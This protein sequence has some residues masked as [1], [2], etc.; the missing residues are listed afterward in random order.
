MIQR[1]A[2][3]GLQKFWLAFF[4]LIVAVTF[5][6]SPIMDSDIFWHLAS[7]EWIFD[8]RHIPRTDI[9]SYT[10]YGNSWIHHE[11]G[12][13]FI[14]FLTMTFFGV[15]GLNVLAVVLFWGYLYFGGRGVSRLTR[16]KGAS[17][18]VVFLLGYLS[19]ERVQPRPH[20]FTNLF[21]AI[22]LYELYGWK[23]IE[24]KHKKKLL[25]ISPFLFMVWANLHGGVLI[26]LALL[27]VYAVGFG[28][29]S[30]ITEGSQKKSGLD[31]TLFYLVL[32]CW[33][34]VLM[35]PYFFHIYTFPFSH[36]RL[37][38]VIGHTLEWMPP[39]HPRFRFRFVFHGYFGL[40][41][42]TLLV[43]CFRWRRQRLEILFPGVLLMFLSIRHARYTALFALWALPLLACSIHG[44]R[45]HL[46]FSP[47]LQRYRLVTIGRTL[48][49]F[50]L[51]YFLIG[52][53]PVEWGVEKQKIGMGIYPH[54]LP[55][56]AV[57]F[58][59]DNGVYQ[60][61]YT[62]D[63]FGSFLI[64]S[65]IPAFIDGRAPVYDEEFWEKTQKSLSNPAVFA[66]LWKKWD[67]G[68]ALL[69]VYLERSMMP[70]HDYLS[71]NP[72]WALIYRDEVASI[73]VDRRKE[74]LA[75]ID[76]FGSKN[77]PL[78]H[79]KNHILP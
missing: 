27:T 36:M 52:G 39:Y 72:Q 59:R 43:I 15:Y 64:Y 25:L 45:W 53:V 54:R 50:I 19:M 10:A 16:S 29:Q 76:K 42:L 70:L 40:L 34:A 32:A 49:F 2:P 68:A 8:N 14:F 24:Q 67:F 9:F 3:P 31:K 47:L 77:K 65:G 35:N 18:L 46:S 30:L 1:I 41:G 57:G 75:L 38:D 20:L 62:K 48:L 12:A 73:Y 11:W 6:L 22:M 26:G 51:S 4:P 7:G 23:E 44:S 69:P 21:I 37:G 17:F 63:T 61:I 28:L 13:S 56:Q 74:N 71:T 33:F 66:E 79:D 5:G 60:R 55:Y 78:V 58:L